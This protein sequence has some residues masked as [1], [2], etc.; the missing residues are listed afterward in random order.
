MTGEKEILCAS[1]QLRRSRQKAGR[2]KR[3]WE[4]AQRKAFE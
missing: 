2:K 3:S 4:M 1:F